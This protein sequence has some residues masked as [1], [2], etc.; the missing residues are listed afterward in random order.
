VCRL[1]RLKLKPKGDPNPLQGCHRAGNYTVTPLLPRRTT[2]MRFELLERV[3]GVAAETTK[4]KNGQVLTFLGCL[5]ELLLVGKFF[6]S[7]WT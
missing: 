1:K 3:S 2:R 5:F 6:E 7:L 4:P